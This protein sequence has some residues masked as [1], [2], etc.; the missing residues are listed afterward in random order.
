MIVVLTVM[1]IVSIVVNSNMALLCC[2]S[3]VIHFVEAVFRKTEAFYL[4]AHLSGK[5]VSDGC[6]MI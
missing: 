4:R 2:I 1:I 5:A 3:R 6:E